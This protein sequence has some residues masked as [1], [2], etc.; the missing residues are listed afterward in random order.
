MWHVSELTDE[1]TGGII[2]WIPGTMMFALSAI[3]VI[4]S[5]SQEETRFNERRQRS[6]G[7]LTAARTQSNGAL[8]LGLAA[9]ALLILVVAIS[10]VSLI[11]HPP[12]GGR[13]YG[14]AGKIP[15]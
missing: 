13:D 6:G 8:A 7:Q 9:G 10:V 3:W 1:Q 11:D 15:G 5:W 12:G 4:Y 14:M 2:M